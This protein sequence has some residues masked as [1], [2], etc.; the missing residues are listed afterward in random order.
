[1]TWRTK[2]SDRFVLRF[3]KRHLSAPLSS[4]L[5]RV[6]PGLTPLPVT[7]TAAC[8]GAAGGLAFGLGHALPG[9]L[10]AAAA[11]VLDGADGQVA[12]LTGRVSRTGAFLDS[13][14]DRIADFALL[15]GVLFH[16]IR[17]SERLQLGAF[18]LSIGWIVAIGCA[19]AIGMSQ[20]SYATARAAALG[21]DYIRPEYAGKGTRTT[22]IVITGLLTPLWIHFPL[23]ALLY[24][25]IHP[26]AAILRSLLLL[27][28]GPSD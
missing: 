5:V 12:R 9:A 3:I 27:R 22:V 14:L 18:T 11:Q 2:P 10:L 15:F 4:T 28:R 8:M 25:A 17:F 21:L 7:I 23:L 24:L 1:M 19:A 6:A 26:N 16:C 20:V 13:V